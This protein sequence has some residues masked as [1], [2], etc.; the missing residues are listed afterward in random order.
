VGETVRLSTTIT[1]KTDKGLPST[2]AIIG[3][4]AG[5]T[6]QPWQLKE[7]QEKNIV[8]YYEV[9]GNNVVVYYR[10]MAPNEEKE[11]NLDLKADMPGEYDA[12]ASS[13][14]LYYTNE[15]KSWDAVDRIKIKKRS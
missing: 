3:I 2:I 9:I 6:A 7:L 12:P 4:P 11:I 5:L 8:D 10:G 14:Y 13:A 1:N 15:F